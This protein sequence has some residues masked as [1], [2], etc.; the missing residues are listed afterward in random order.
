MQDAQLSII[1]PLIVTGEPLTAIE[2]SGAL[3]MR[4]SEKDP[5]LLTRMKGADLVTPPL[6]PSCGGEDE[7]R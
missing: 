4:T 6:P 5:A 7:G 2:R 1:I 3:R